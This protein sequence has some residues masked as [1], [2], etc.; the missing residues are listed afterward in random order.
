ME[1]STIGLD[2]AKNA[3]QV[4][5]I[6]ASGEVVIRKA[7]RR[8]QMLSFFEKLP[9]CPI[10][11]EACGTSHHWAREQKA[12]PSLHRVRNLLIK[13]RTQ[14]ANMMCSVLAELGAP[15]QS[16]YERRCRSRARS[17][18]PKR[19]EIS[20]RTSLSRSAGATGPF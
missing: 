2:L 3:F 19:V 5:G 14:L 4:H 1:I 10:G 8:S 13:Q 15:S 6:S 20:G 17:S 11:A 9:P 7:Q 16:R 18:S 12:A